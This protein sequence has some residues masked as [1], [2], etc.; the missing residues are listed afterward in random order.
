MKY[1]IVSPRYEGDT[2][3]TIQEKKCTVG[4]AWFLPGFE[5]SV[6]SH[7]LKEMVDY[8]AIDSIIKS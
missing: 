1:I 2:L 7:F 5:I 3:E 6:G 8:F 4:I